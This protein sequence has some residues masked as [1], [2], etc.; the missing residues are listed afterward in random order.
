[1]TF[2]LLKNEEEIQL[3]HA[4]YAMPWMQ[5]LLEDY[6]EWLVESKNRKKFANVTEAQASQ[7]GVK[8]FI[9]YLD[10]KEESVETFSH[11]YLEELNIDSGKTRT[12]TTN[13]DIC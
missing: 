1:M 3:V 4:K 8:G 6:K 5:E 11:D 12:I 7:G 13:P 10:L 9:W 2:F